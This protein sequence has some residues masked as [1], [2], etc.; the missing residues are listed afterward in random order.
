VIVD[1]AGVEAEEAFLLIVV[2]V[3]VVVEE[4]LATIEALE[5]DQ[6]LMIGPM[7]SMIDTRKQNSYCWADHL[8]NVLFMDVFVLDSLLEIR[9]AESECASAC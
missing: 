9:L 8:V 1:L 7:P 6:V 4:A 5:I 3:V 2:V